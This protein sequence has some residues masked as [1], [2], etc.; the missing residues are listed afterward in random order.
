MP[1]TIPPRS[2]ALRGLAGPHR[3]GAA[4][5]LLL[6]ALFVL[7]GCDAGFHA[8]PFV[9]EDL[10]VVHGAVP[11]CHE[12]VGLHVSIRNTSSRA[13]AAFSHSFYLFAE[14]GAPLGTLQT[15]RVRGE[16]E[17][18]LEAGASEGYCTSLDSVF[19]FLPGES[20]QVRQYRIDEVRFDD[21]DRWAPLTATYAYPY[22]AR[23]EQPGE[24]AP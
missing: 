11:G 2:R 20:T 23:S 3:A 4:L 22:P 8:A 18:A 21:G 19:H 7:A 12:H 24:D 10:A 13:F 14:D 9:Y 5:P 6:P 16:V 1:V 15:R 17:A